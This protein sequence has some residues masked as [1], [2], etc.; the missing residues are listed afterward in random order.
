MDMKDRFDARSRQD[1]LAEDHSPLAWVAP[2]LAFSLVAMVFYLLRGIL[3]AR[4]PVINKDVFNVVL[5]AL[6]TAFTTIIS[7]YFGSSVGSRDKD[8]AVNSGRLISN[9]KTVP[10]EDGSTTDEDEGGEPD[11]TGTRTPVQ[12]GPSGGAP[13]KPLP[14][15]FGPVGTFRQ[16]APAYHAGSS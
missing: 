10:V 11:R 3:V 1:K 12:K 4:E 7:F 6:V 2:I 15:S 5:G 13:P 9:P 16:L 14:P 8:R